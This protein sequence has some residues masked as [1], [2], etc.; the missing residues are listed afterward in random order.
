M[1]EWNL[2]YILDCDLAY[3]PDLHD[4]HNDYPLAAERLDIHVEL[5]SETQVA[6]SRH[7]P[8]TRAAKNFK[9]VPNLMSMKNYVVYYRNVK[10]YL[11][12]GMRRTKIHRAIGFS[13]TRWI[14]PYIFLNT[15]M[16]AAEKNDKE[17]DFHKLMNCAVYGKT[18]QNQR[19]RTH[20]HLGNDRVKAG[21][22]VDNPH[23][24]DARIFNE[25]LVG[26]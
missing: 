14:E 17:K 26:I 24:L 2:G 19:K 16:G 20:I 15:R 7:Y 10:F 13:L 5:L 25:M 8:R 22:L 1:D 4:A 21:K 3:V 18:G 11:D 6:I 23:C 9:L 12:H